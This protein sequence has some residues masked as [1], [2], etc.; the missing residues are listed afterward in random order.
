M[1]KQLLKKNREKAG[2]INGLLTLQKRSLIERV[3]TEHLFEAGITSIG[4]L[5]VNL[6]FA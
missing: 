5:K 4:S 1:A 6:A 2:D 3:V